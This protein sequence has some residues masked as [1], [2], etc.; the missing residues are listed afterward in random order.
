[1]NQPSL[2]SALRQDFA[3]CQRLCFEGTGKLT[4]ELS[5]NKTQQLERFVRQWASAKVRIILV[6]GRRVG[7]LQTAPT[8]DALDLGQL[9]VDRRFQRRG[10]GRGVL[11]ALI[12]EATR[13]NMAMTVA[14]AKNNPARRLYLR[15][16]F[17]VVYE[18]RFNLY[19]RRE[20]INAPN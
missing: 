6:A 19:L 9:Y 1:V 18:D 8:D 20:P 12:K 17:R 2:R 11:Q 16:G 5:L 10:I 4:E 7:W 14:V 13:D 3:F 15:H